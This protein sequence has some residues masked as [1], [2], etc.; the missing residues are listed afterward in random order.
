[1]VELALVR[2]IFLISYLSFY[3]LIHIPLDFYMLIRKGKASY[4]R[5][6]F[7]SLYEGISVVVPT[8]IFWIF[9]L[10]APIVYFVSD[11][12]ILTLTIVDD[13][14]Q[15][16][17]F[18]IGSIFMFLGLIV[19]C[20]GRIDR[21]VYLSKDEPE[22]ATKF[23]HAIVRHPSYF[24]YFTGFIGLP[25]VAFSPYLLILLFG[26]PGYLITIKHEEE[27][28]LEFFNEKFIEYCENVG[29]IIPKIRK[30]K[31]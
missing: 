13:N 19:G 5:A 27:G 11:I 3:L 7:N 24:L 21:G 2:Y 6:S 26:I 1:M 31:S 14:I 28:L 4:P 25:L 8:M 23:G 15:L 17:V 9:L 12:S 20:L 22:L 16:P 10:V 30:R 29:K 18:I